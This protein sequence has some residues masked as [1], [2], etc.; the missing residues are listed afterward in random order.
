VRADEPLS[1]HT[2]FGI[3]GP[4]QYWVEVS[5]EAELAAVLAVVA[6]R[7]MRWWVLGRGSNVLISDQGLP[8]MV[9]RLSG[10]LARIEVMV[11]QGEPQR[12]RANRVD[13]G[14]S[15]PVLLPADGVLHCG[16]GAGL[17]EVAT[18]AEAA[19]LCGAEFLAGIP[20]TVGGGLRTNAG[21]FGRSL[22]DIVEEVRVMDSDGSS[23]L[24]TGAELNRGY[25]TS[26]VP[27]GVIAV[28]AKLDLVPGVPTP[29]GEV[30]SR[31]RE[32]Q[33]NLPSAG[34][35]F[36]NPAGEPAGRLIERCGLKG[37]RV[38][39]AEVSEKHANFIVNTG[40]TRF[41]DVYGLAQVVK[42]NV[43]EQTGILLEEEVQVLPGG[44]HGEVHSD[45]CN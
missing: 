20:G 38:G 13:A 39:A 35:F 44:E 25:R 37:R 18:A 26:V 3:G 29:T 23:R 24:L 45:R 4:A 41:A 11:E 33:P 16:G 36:K 5:S 9:L 27:E 42:A 40:G 19:G 10:E 12:Y 15:K 31:R 34:S 1:R 21:A 6:V 2:T 30:R 28:R 22:S 17:D 7:R 14:G 43:E 32:K 8:G